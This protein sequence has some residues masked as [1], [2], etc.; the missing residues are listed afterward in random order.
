MKCISNDK[1]CVRVRSS[2]F[3]FFFFCFILLS[4]DVTVDESPVKV[5]LADTAGQDFLD[6]LRRLCYPDSDVFLLCFSV[7][8]PDTFVAVREKWAPIFRKTHKPIVLIGTQSDL[9]SD[10]AVISQLL[11]NIRSI[12]CFMN[13]KSMM[14]CEMADRHRECKIEWMSKTFKL[15]LILEYCFSLIFAH[16]ILQNSK[17]IWNEITKFYFP[18]AKNEKPV[19]RTD[20]FDYATLIGAKYIETSSRVNVSIT[21][22]IILHSLR[23]NDCVGMEFVLHQGSSGCASNLSFTNSIHNAVTYFHN[24]ISHSKWSQQHGFFSTIWHL[25][26]PSFFLHSTSAYKIF[27]GHVI[28]KQ[29]IPFMQ[30]FEG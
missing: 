13:F 9:R 18:Q 20:A 5:E 14:S 2:C 29:N 28:Q 1:N 19:S 22:L 23:S 16:Y 21:T 24:R 10:S 17:C 25:F 8:K 4:V 7:I 26:L 27:M 12:C 15:S 6:P 11:V 30:R 3:F